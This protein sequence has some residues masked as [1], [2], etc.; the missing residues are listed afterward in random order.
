[1]RFAGPARFELGQIVG[2]PHAVRFCGE[3]HIDIFDLLVRHASGDWGALSADD[4]KAN[5]AALV[6]GSRILSSY[7][8]PAGKVWVLTEANG[9]DFHRAS[10]CVMLPSDY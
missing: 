4:E 2:T 9:D 10:T 7:T 8:F 3:H 6:D 5:D 1:V